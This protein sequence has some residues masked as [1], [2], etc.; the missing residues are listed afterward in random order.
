MYWSWGSSHA[1]R[2]YDPRIFEQYN[3]KLFSLGSSSQTPV[4]TAYLFDKY[5]SKFHPKLVIIDVYPILFKSDGVESVIDLV[6]NAELDA[7]LVDL[8]L[9]QNNI[10][11]YNTLC[12]RA[13]SDALDLNQNFTEESPNETGDVYVSGGYVQSF[14][15]FK[16]KSHYDETTYSF[17]PEQMAAFERIVNQ[18]RN[19]KIPYLILQSTIPQAKYKHV[20]NNA[21]A[22]SYFSKFGFYRNANEA[23]K[24]PDSC[25]LDESHLNQSGVIHYN[26][27][28]VDLIKKTGYLKINDGRYQMASKMN[29]KTAFIPK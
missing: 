7:D 17:L 24:L 1:Y 21:F 27:Y 8:S 25:F 28:V 15:R 13:V 12:Y 18:L 11:V 9:S 19:D 26:K 6:S 16:G 20:T 14:G 4:Q 22:D 2:G 3:W 29:S 10:S 5:I 23:L